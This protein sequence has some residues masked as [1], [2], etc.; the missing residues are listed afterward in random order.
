[1]VIGAVSKF[2][3][4]EIDVVIAQGD[5]TETV[6]E[7]ENK[8]ESCRKRYV[9][10]NQAFW[11]RSLNHCCVTCKAHHY[12]SL[13]ARYVRVIKTLEISVAQESCH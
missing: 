5:I 4:L 11:K 13:H 8:R 9:E 3:K 6:K 12:D 2:V 7:N 1:M 10:L